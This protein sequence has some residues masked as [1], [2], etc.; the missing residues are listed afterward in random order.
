MWIKK[1]QAPTFAPL[2]L[3]GTTLEVTAEFSDVGY[4]TNH[5]LSWNF[6]IDKISS[7]VNKV[8]ALIKRNC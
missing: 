8:L 5:K 3:R 6:H 7:K 2:Q 1:N 4:P